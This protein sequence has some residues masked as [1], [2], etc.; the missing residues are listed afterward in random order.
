MCIE[1]FPLLRE[2]TGGGDTGIRGAGDG[3]KGAGDRGKWGGGRGKLERE[4]GEEEAG[5]GKFWG[6]GLYKN[7]LYFTDFY[8]IL[9]YFNAITGYQNFLI[10]ILK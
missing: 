5:V 4:T 10:D 7:V 9:T 1:I 2:W 8:T 6:R 3:V